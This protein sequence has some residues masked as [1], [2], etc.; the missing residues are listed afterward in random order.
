[1]KLKA[2]IVTG[3]MLAIS[4]GAQAKGEQAQSALVQSLERCRPITNDMER[5]RCYDVAAQALTDAAA[6]GNVVILDQEAA[7]KT[8]SALFGFNIPKLPL[9]SGDKST[10]QDE[11]TAKITSV[12]ELPYGKWQIRI[13][14]GALWE[15]TETSAAVSNP[16]AGNMVVIRRGPLGSYM[17]RIDG[18]RALRAKRVG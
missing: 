17:M 16:R 11:I 15:T 4:S 7:R 6:Q 13:E 1:M 18:Q 8:R 9:F 10:V 12:R 14:D 5:L 3:A 2:F